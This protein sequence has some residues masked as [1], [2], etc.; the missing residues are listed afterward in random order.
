ME[1]AVVLAAGLGVVGEVTL[2]GGDDGLL[3]GGNGGGISSIDDLLD[4]NGGG[5]SSKPPTVWF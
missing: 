3:L 1:L 2:V 5:M 4:G